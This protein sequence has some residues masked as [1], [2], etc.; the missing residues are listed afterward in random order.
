MIVLVAFVITRPA[1]IIS[2]TFPPGIFDCKFFLLFFHVT[3]V[4]QQCSI[5]TALLASSKDLINC[6]NLVTE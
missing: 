6:I 3:I 2:A 4:I 5:T 1:P